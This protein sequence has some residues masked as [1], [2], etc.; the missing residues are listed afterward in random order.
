MVMPPNTTRVIWFEQK[1]QLSM[2][3]LVFMK[4]NE[5][6]WMNTEMAVKLDI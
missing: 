3:T 5:G 4:F 2:F 6:Q 1:K